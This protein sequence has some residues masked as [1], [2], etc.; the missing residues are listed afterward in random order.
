[1]HGSFTVSELAHHVGG[2]VEGNGEHR[3]H[4][5]A[6][7][8]TAES[9]HVSFLA[10]RRYAK[11]LPH[12]TA[13]A[14]LVSDKER[15]AKN[16]PTLIFCKDPYTAFAQVLQLFH[17]TRRPEPGIDPRAYVAPSAQTEGATIEAFAWVGPAA[18][19]GAGSWVQAGVRIGAQAIVGKDCVLMANSVVCD[20]CRLGD[21]V[22]LN[23]GAVVGGEGF[24]FAPS[25]TGHTKI[26]QVGTAVVED[27]VEVGS[28]SCIDRAAMADTVVRRGAKLDNLVQVGHAAEIGEHALM[29]AYSGVAGS[30]QLGPF[31]TMAAKSAILGHLQIGQGVQVGVGS[32]VHDN[33]QDGAKVTGNP[34][35]PHRTWLR[36]ATAFK[37]LPDIAK[38]VRRLEAKVTKLESGLDDHPTIQSPDD[39]EL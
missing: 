27:D 34:A 36:A 3:I 16:A 37:D 18:S 21:R 29:V 10:N 7:L 6:G 25:A 30:S 33:Q 2:T 4:G 11:M 17:P 14:V 23:P 8:E 19:V 38:Q 24:G 5:V 31:V 1:M 9:H 32:A 13:G 35:I 20:G 15:D 26:P 39:E 12:S 28:N 22:W